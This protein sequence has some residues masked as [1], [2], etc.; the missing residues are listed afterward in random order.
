MYLCLLLGV[1][2]EY[3]GLDAFYL[4]KFVASDLINL[5]F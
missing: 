1:K 5:I 4:R 2:L 3:Y